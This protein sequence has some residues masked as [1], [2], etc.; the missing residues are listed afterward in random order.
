MSVYKSQD[1]AENG[2]EAHNTWREK[3]VLPHPICF[4]KTLTFIIF[5][6]EVPRQ[7]PCDNQF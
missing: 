5:V 6:D 4:A 3:S 7:L 2:I 1:W